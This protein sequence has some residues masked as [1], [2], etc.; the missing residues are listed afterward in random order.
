MKTTDIRREYVAARLIPR[1]YKNTP[2]CIRFELAAFDVDE[3]APYVFDS[4]FE[5]LTPADA[6]VLTR[7]RYLTRTER[8]EIK[9]TTGKTRLFAEPKYYRVIAYRGKPITAEEYTDVVDALRDAAIRCEQPAQA[10]TPAQ[11]TDT[12]V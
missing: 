7:R 6:L 11:G 2:D 9:A 3:I 8:E 1:R 4:L 12:N 10:P 5:K